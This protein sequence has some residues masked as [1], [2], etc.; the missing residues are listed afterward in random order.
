MEGQGILANTSYE[1]A[2]GDYGAFLK[3]SAGG[4]SHVRVKKTKQGSTNV[5]KNILFFIT[6]MIFKI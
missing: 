1:E 4:P 6:K 2:G 5:L 3:T